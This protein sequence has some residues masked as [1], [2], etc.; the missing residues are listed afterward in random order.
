MA[1]DDLEMSESWM[2]WG[3]RKICPATQDLTGKGQG[4]H[5]VHGGP[6]SMSEGSPGPITDSTFQVQGGTVAAQS[7]FYEPTSLVPS[8]PP[9]NTQTSRE[10]MREKCLCPGH[11]GARD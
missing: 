5:I 1:L 3:A 10:L 4:L 9:V 8:F 11:S 6:G 7:V 2:L